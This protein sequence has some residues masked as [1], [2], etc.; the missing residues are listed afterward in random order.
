M[1]SPTR[2]RVHLLIDQLSEHELTT[3][4]RVLTE[5]RQENDPVSRA[6]ANAPIDDEPLTPE[7]EA[8]LAEG[9]A[10]LAAGRTVSDDELWRR[11]DHV[12]EH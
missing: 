2:E 8:A 11:L 3:A 12:A 6:L 10:D 4:E 1:T 9:Y 7:E 5:L